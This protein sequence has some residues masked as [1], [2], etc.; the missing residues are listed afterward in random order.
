MGCLERCVFFVFW[1]RKYLGYCGIFVDYKLYIY[2]MQP[3][4]LV[5]LPRELGDFVANVGI[6]IPAPWLAYGIYNGET[7]KQ[8]VKLIGG[9]KHF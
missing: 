4:V 2:H 5:Y 8:R 1:E 7:I 6:H 3:M 9:F